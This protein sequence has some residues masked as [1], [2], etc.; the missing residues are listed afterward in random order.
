MPETAAFVGIPED[1][2]I[3]KEDIFYDAFEYPVIPAGIIIEDVL[4]KDV[5]NDEDNKICNLCSAPCNCALGKEEQRRESL[6][7]IGISFSTYVS[8]ADP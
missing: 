4:V 3:K 1:K 2:L 6:K 5:Y 8:S 7:P